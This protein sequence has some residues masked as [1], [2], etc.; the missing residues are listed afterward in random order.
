MSGVKVT[1]RRVFADGELAAYR[2]VVGK[3]GS[4]IILIGEANPYTPDPRMAL[5]PYPPAAAGARL[6]RHLGV[7]HSEFLSVW[8]AN[9]C[10]SFWSPDL[11]RRRAQ[12]LSSPGMPWSVVVLLGRQVATA[13]GHSDDLMTTK[14]VGSLV[15]VILPHSSGMNRVWNDKAAVHRAQTIMRAVAPEIPWGSS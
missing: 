11:A 10:R 1:E 15:Y 5:F 13:M 4:R 7:V 8:R 9:L 3:V 12:A 14:V 2:S 6:R